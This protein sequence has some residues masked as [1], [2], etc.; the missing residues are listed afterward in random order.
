MCSGIEF[1]ASGLMCLF[2]IIITTITNTVYVQGVNFKR[3]WEVHECVAAIDLID[4]QT[5]SLKTLFQEAVKS[6]AFLRSAEVSTAGPCHLHTMTRKF[7]R[8]ETTP[9]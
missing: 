1:H 2:I 9:V 7:Q 8:A 3:L 5:D 4:Q 6:N